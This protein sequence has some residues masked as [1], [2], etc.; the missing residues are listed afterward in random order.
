MSNAPVCVTMA[1][2]AQK[3]VYFTPVFGGFQLSLSYT[4]NGGD[5]RHGDGVGR[6]YRHA[7]QQRRGIAA[8]RL[9]VPMDLLYEGDGWAPDCGR[10]RLFEGHVEQSAGPDRD[11]QQFY[12]TGFNL[13]FGNFAVGGVFEY[14]NDALDRSGEGGDVGR[15]VV[16]DAWVAGGG[17][18]YTIDAW[19]FGAQYSHQLDANRRLRRRRRPRT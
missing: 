12:Q 15:P 14:Y 7:V 4:P 2:D 9:G 6:A 5:R 16:D 17:V 8:Q 10:R 3:L 1:S 11:E 18:A 19:A 13:T